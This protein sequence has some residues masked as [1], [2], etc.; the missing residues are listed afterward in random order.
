MKVLITGA[1]GFI[2]SHLMEK[3]SAEGYETIGLDSFRWYT[4]HMRNTV[5]GDIRNKRL[6]EGLVKRVDEVYHLAAQINVDYGNKHPQETIDI[7]V[8]GTLN[9]LE[10]CRKYNK[11]LIYAS[12]SEVYGTAQKE[13]ISE[14]HP[15][16]AQSVY[17]ASKLAAERLCKAY[18][19]T[20]SVDARILRSFNTFG[21]FQRF[22][23]YGGVIAIFVDRA[24]HHKPCI[25]Y[26]NGEQQR[27]YISIEDAL[28]GYEI[29][30]TEAEPGKPF[31]IGSGETITI[32]ELARLVQKY[33]ACPEPIH[34]APRPGEVQCLR[35]DI[36]YAKKLGFTP[37]TNFEQK[38]KDYI[39]WKRSTL[40]Q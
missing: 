27:D 36:T 17:A 5:I 12:S 4:R 31:N 38:L 11:R 19:D 24:L 1:V 37:T 32:N 30:A 2:G 3:M 13:K 39:D 14:N 15:T 9:V 10:A 8:S 34:V 33:T 20:F 28:R 26:G 6:V 29:A 16:D 23:S 7:N 40:Q 21:N 35:A 18:T 25:I 22:D